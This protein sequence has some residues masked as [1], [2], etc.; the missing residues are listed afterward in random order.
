MN[1]AS[2]SPYQ[3]SNWA[4]AGLPQTR[5]LTEELKNLD[6]IPAILAYLAEELKNLFSLFVGAWISNQILTSVNTMHATQF[7]SSPYF[8]LFG[9]KDAE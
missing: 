8:K 9:W 7:R 1:E 4:K 6:Q 3:L 2:V 5:E